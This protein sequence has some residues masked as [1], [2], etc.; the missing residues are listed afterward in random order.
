[1]P[2]CYSPW[3][4]IDISPQGKISPCC[5]FRHDLYSAPAVSTSDS[6]DNYESS[7]TLIEIKQNFQD[8]QWPLGCERCKIEEDNGIESKRQL[9]YVRWKELYDCHDIENGG[10]LTASMAFGNTCNLKCLT[11][12]PSSSSSWHR[13]WLDLY[14]QDIRPNHF[15]KSN[16]TEQ[17]FDRMPHLRHLDIP[18]GEPF[19]SGVKEQKRLLEKWIAKGQAHKI[20]LHYT[21]NATFFPDGSWWDLWKHFQ[22]IDIQLSVDGL[23]RR[24]EYIRFPAA[25]SVVEDSV[26][27]YLDRQAHNIQISVSH[28]VSAYN[29]YYLPEFFSW[30]FDI[31]LPRPWLGRVHTPEHLRPTVWQGAAKSFI[32]DHL[33]QCHFD[34][35]QVW[36]DLLIRDDDSLYFDRF[37]DSIVRHDQ[38]RHTEFQSAFPELA[39]WIKK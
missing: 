2:F 11:C 37:V 22:N 6:L 35:V 15:Y 9:D 8:G 38:Y 13:E 20:S 19:V 21:T 24:L 36:A 29:I 7:A 30:C 25:W 10:Y 23:G 1:M 18:G 16:F 3:T 12:G 33:R 39:P 14:G 28:T 31:G 32:V 5:K 26:R 34:D 17:L 4:N 27:K